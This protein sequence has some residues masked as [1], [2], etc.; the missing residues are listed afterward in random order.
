MRGTSGDDVIEGEFERLVRRERDFQCKIGMARCLVRC[1]VGM[2]CV[3]DGPMKLGRIACQWLFN[4][5]S[6]TR[7]LVVT[8]VI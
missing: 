7:R 2:V 8:I 5:Q 6:E 4:G 3:E 1:R